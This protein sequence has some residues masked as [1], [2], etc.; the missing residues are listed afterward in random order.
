[1]AK[2]EVIIPDPIVQSPISEKEKL[3]LLTPDRLL[4]VMMEKGT[5]EAVGPPKAL[6]HL[7]AINKTQSMRTHL[8]HSRTKSCMDNDSS[9][10]TSIKK[11]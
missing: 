1:M 11:D 7:L 9:L 6:S 2:V 8:K 5:V 4:S 10:T 3:Y